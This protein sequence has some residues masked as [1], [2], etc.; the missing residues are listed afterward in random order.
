LEENVLPWLGTVPEITK[1]A[2]FA[3]IERTLCAM[4]AGVGLLETVNDIGLALITF[5][6][7][8]GDGITYCGFF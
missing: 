2:T 6:Y 3:H 4:K 8:V 5:G 7:D 1:D